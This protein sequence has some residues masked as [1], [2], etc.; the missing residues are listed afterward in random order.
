MISARQSSVALRR[1]G[2][3]VAL[4]PL[5]C[6]LATPDAMAADM[7]PGEGGGLAE[8]DEA[9]L[10]E[11]G[12]DPRLATYFRDA[13]RFTAGVHRVALSVNGQSKGPV[14]TRF[15]ANGDLCFNR[16][17]LNAAEIVVPRKAAAVEGAGVDGSSEGCIDLMAA[18]PQTTIELKPGKAEVSLLVP[19][20]ALRERREDLSGYD[21]GGT[22]GVFNYD[23]I[24]L[25]NRS[26]RD[27]REY[28]SANTE[29]GFNAGDWV[30]R[31]R[32]VV[33][34]ND[35]EWQTTRLDAYA[36]R[37]FAERRAVLQV[38]ELN[39]S[40]PVL[41]GAQ[42][43]GVQ[44]GTEQAL[45][46]TRRGGTIEGIARSQARVE[47]RQGGLL[48]HSAVV[49]AGPFTLRDVSRINGRSD[50]E[51]TVFE[52]D[53]TQRRFTVPAAA[54]AV[55]P[56]SAGYTFGAGKV[57]NVGGAAKAP[58]VVNA[59]WSGPGVRGSALSGGAVLAQGYAALGGGWTMSIGSG[60]SIQG[61]VQASH[62]RRPRTRGL[63]ASV[64]VAQQLSERW[65]FQASATQQTV[66]YRDLLDSVQ[67]ANAMQGGSR[68]KRQYSGNL[69]WSHPRL[70]GL[71][72]GV[73]R[74]IQ[75]SRAATSNGFA[76]W[77]TRI[78]KA[79]ASLSANWALGGRGRK[80]DNALYLNVNVPLGETRSLNATMRDRRGEVRTGVGL[81]GSVNDQV[82]YR[83]S[84]ER[85]S[86]SP[87]TDFA[88]GVSL[89]PRYTQ[90]D[91][92]YASQ[93]GGDSVT[94]GMSGGVAVHGHGITTSPYRIQDTFG[95]LALPGASGIKV[96]TP[97]GPVWTDGRGYAVLPQL[98]PFGR[99]TIEVE[100]RSLPRNVDVSKGSAVIKVGR[101]AVRTIDFRVARTRRVLL[102]ATLPDGRPLHDGAVVS[103][104]NDDLVSLVQTGGQVFVPNA[105]TTP[106]LWAEE[107]GQP[108][109]ELE[110]ALPEQAD[111][112]A[113][114]ETAAAVCR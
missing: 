49:P 32:Q 107:P 92:G 83:A 30:V 35:G 14:E 39:L 99:S 70:G 94:L 36:Q 40:N 93:G 75:F 51:V 17:F 76:S 53:G 57:R 82:R 52:A 96:S 85:G 72:G 88:A 6:S 73:T 2:L 1:A 90:L 71:S 29:V 15:A 8:F 26:G 69:S 16:A 66:G 50:V 80:R 4:L 33:T 10:T 3:R 24:G 63:Q 62:A 97:S 87:Q 104:E 27:S 103:D 42:I 91:V 108:R 7:A 28:W 41:P 65:S 18:Y 67:R 45:A 55:A 105:L 48:I 112:D 60:A 106:R 20:D 109:C 111:A 114:F 86:R 95:L 77:S 64:S 113:Y 89:V 56:P 23:V 74:T 46:S 12:I 98:A 5:A 21:R 59:G 22:A 84:A 19:T 102:E 100:T 110:Y 38:G 101:G 34:S 44:I 13:P 31:S 47:V 68:F 81:S 11:R 9:M 61:Y 78:G 25:H 79:S 54:Y 58:W 43:L 37:S